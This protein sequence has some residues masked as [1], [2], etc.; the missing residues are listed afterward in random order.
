MLQVG[1]IIIAAVPGEFTTMAGRRL[2]RVLENTIFNVTQGTQN[3]KVVVAG[4]SNAYTHYINTQEEYQK[5]R[6]KAASTMFGPNITPP[7]WRDLV[8]ILTR[9]L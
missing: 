1:N 3:L 9:K 2:K 6:Y 4:L 8:K 7:L 5:Q